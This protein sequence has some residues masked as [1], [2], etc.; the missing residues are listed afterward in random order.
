MKLEILQEV[1]LAVTRSRSLDEVLRGLVDGLDEHLD[2]ALVRLWLVRPGDQCGTCPMAAE[3][4]T[5]V[6]CLHL[7]AS[8]GTPTK[9]RARRPTRLD[10]AYRRFPIGARKV[11]HIAATGEPLEIPDVRDCGGWIKDPAWARA[12]GV[13]SPPP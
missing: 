2:L 10:G 7:V 6:P 4:E 13:G 5:Q 9:K 3:C 1:A 12:Q 8:Q 11:G